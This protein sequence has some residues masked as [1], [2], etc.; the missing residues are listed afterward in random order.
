MGLKWKHSLDRIEEE[1]NGD[2][3][4]IGGEEDH[5]EGLQFLAER[6]MRSL[7]RVSPVMDTAEWAALIGPDSRYWALIG[8]HL[9][10]FSHKVYAI[11][12]RFM[13]FN[14]LL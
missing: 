14:V 2:P 6:D 13:T 5:V 8:G 4:L 9:T 10:I 1:A 11:T 7:H 3:D 12:T